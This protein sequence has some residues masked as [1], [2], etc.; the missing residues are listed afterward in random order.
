MPVT[1]VLTASY[2]VAL[3]VVARNPEG[4]WGVLASIFPFT[5]PIAMPVR[6]AGG[7]VPVWQ[8]LLSMALTIGTAV[9]LVWLASAIYRRA[10]VIT[11]RRVKVTE[12]FRSGTQA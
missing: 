3:T 8:L 12:V 5:A 1:L 7:L 6:W 10:L 9:L 2:I 4:V 11:G